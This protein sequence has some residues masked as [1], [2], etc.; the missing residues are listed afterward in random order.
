MKMTRTCFRISRIEN[1]GRVTS[2][3]GPSMITDSIQ[4]C[5][6]EMMG[7]RGRGPQGKGL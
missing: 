6:V 4:V 1:K 7:R 5:F 2:R 3:K